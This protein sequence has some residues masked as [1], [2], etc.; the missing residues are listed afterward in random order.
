MSRKAILLTSGTTWTVPADWNDV[1]STIICIGGGGGGNRDATHNAS[2]ANYR[3]AG[4]GGGGAWASSSSLGLTANQTVYINI[5]AG[6]AGASSGLTEIGD[7]GGDT[8]LNKITN[9]APGSSSNGLLAKGAAQA[10]TYNV[11]GVGGSAASSIGNTIYAGGNGGIGEVGSTR[12]SAGGGGSAGS[13]RGTG[14]N[15]GAGDN[16][17]LA[18]GGGGGGAGGAGAVGSQSGGGDG[19]LNYYGFTGGSGGVGATAPTSGNN[20]GG[21]GGGD[22]GVSPNGATGAYGEEY[23]ITAGGSAGSGG[24]AGGGAGSSTV[25]GGNG[26]SGGLYGGG[27]G[28]G[29]GGVGGTTTGGNGAQ[30]AIIIIYDTITNIS[31]SNTGILSSNSGLLDEIGQYM[32]FYDELNTTLYFDATGRLPYST[33]T[34][35]NWLNLALST[36][37]IVANTTALGATVAN[38]YGPNAM[39]FNNTSATAGRIDRTAASN[40][41][42]VPGA[43]SGTGKM[44]AA[45]WAYH[46][47]WYTTS[48]QRFVSST[49]GGGWSIAINDAGFTGTTSVGIAFYNDTA[50]GYRY[51]EA[52]T[53]NAFT[54]STGWNHL[55]WT[56][57]GKYGFFYI[58]GQVANTYTAAAATNYMNVGGCLAIGAEAS[59]SIATT[60]PYLSGAMA[61]IFVSNRSFTNTEI[62]NLFVDTDPNITLPG[63]RT[64]VVNSTY[65][66]NTTIIPNTPAKYY[67]NGALRATGT[68]GFDEVTMN[69]GSLF[70]NGSTQYLTGPAT[71][72][73]LGT[74]NF[75]IEMWVNP[76]TVSS[77]SGYCLL[78]TRPAGSGSTGWVVTIQSGN[79]T[80]QNNGTQYLTSTGTISAGTWSHIAWV[81]VGTTVTIYINGV[82]SGT[83]TNSTDHTASLF[84]VAKP[85]FTSSSQLN[86]GGYI[87]NVRIV[88]GIAQYTSNF[89]PPSSSVLVAV[90]NT[91][92]LLQV[93]N[94]SAYITDS[95]PNQY[96]ITNNGTVG[97]SPLGIGYL[98]TLQCGSLSFDG[99]SQYL[100]LSA[101]PVVS[102]G[103]FTIEAWIYT[104]VSATQIIYSQYNAFN[105]NRWLFNIDNNSGYKL[106]FG[107]GTAPGVISGST[108]VPLNQWNHVAVT[109]DASNTLRFFLNGVLDG[110][111]AGYTYS[112]YESNPRI[113]GFDGVGTYNFNGYM[114]NIRISN[115]ALY[116]TSFTP[117][118]KLLTSLSS[119]TLLLQVANSSAYITDSSPS[120][121]TITNNGTVP[122]TAF[123]PLY[124]LG[125]AQKIYSDGTIRVA[126]YLDETQ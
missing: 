110:T 17:T 52:N 118:K 18:G 71:P 82:A 122:Y 121:L 120:P 69:S 67:S 35:G 108:I 27:G 80:I 99:S 56:F 70:F 79:I 102:A 100:T 50:G 4:G 58:N 105:G 26:G 125:E 111:Y 74:G 66:T 112:L 98:N 37:S 53:R 78:D 116:T 97:Y 57:D 123:T 30:G 65:S 85:T 117:P 77:A 33:S 3:A 62:Y 12:Y 126:N 64:Y 93:A 34:S 14:G 9:A 124:S 55:A 32:T 95:S 109:R 68:I 28:G 73:A 42:I 13:A 1:G 6:G 86:Y 114:T 90:A 89:T 91:S 22:S 19:G 54:S 46:T 29:G 81:R 25:L 38:T 96:T 43:T 76:T 48:G 84:G 36:K 21:G 2:G 103:Q 104:T 47:N 31:V 23:A 5:G 88:P 101:N 45:V 113:S 15:G 10:A 92:L 41:I 59:L 11:G 94:S 8:W 16:V 49:Q 83:A 7:A 75:T 39:I 119:T 24:G 51:M 106:N 87:T 72:A 60:S 63:S 61:S 20:G 115:T 107:H 44:T 40:T